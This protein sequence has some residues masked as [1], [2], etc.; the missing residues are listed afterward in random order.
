MKFP[1]R[2]L[3]GFF[4]KGATTVFKGLLSYVF[5]GEKKK[6]TTLPGLIIFPILMSIMSLQ[7]K[8]LTRSLIPLSYL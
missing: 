4:G 8:L 1:R 6:N 2:K 5:L 7:L 3:S